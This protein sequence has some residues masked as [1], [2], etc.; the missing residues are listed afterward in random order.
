MKKFFFLPAT[1]FAAILV[2]IYSISNSL[3]SPESMS[4]IE[5]EVARVAERYIAIH[6]PDFDSTKN[7][8]IVNDDGDRWKVAYK[9]PKGM[10][11]GTPIIIIEKSTLKV[12][13]AY[14]TQ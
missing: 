9:L 11:G 8:P 10:I 14:R 3:A 7:H 13:D 5:C 6:Y 1:L 4:P 2:F 12:L